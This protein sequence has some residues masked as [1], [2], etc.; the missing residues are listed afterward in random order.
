VPRSSDG[1]K[2]S[3][4]NSLRRRSQAAVRRA[5]S[6]FGGLGR[7]E[8]DDSPIS[9]KE[10]QKDR[11]I[12]RSRS[13]SVRIKRRPTSMVSLREESFDSDLLPG[14]ER[15]HRKMDEI[16]RCLDNGSDEMFVKALKKM[17]YMVAGSIV[18][19]EA[20]D[21][22]LFAT[23]EHPAKP[24]PNKYTD[25]TLT[26]EF[27]K[28]RLK[29]IEERHGKKAAKVEK[30]HIQGRQETTLT[31]TY[32]Y[33]DSLHPTQR[34]SVIGMLTHLA[35]NEGQARYEYMANAGVTEKAGIILMSS[36]LA[37]C[38][39]T[40]AYEYMEHVPP[41]EL[42]AI[43]KMQEHLEENNGKGAYQY[44]SHLPLDELR[45]LVSNLRQIQVTAER[46]D[47][48]TR[49]LI[50]AERK[51]DT[52]KLTESGGYTLI[53][54]GSD[55]ELTDSDTLSSR[56]SLNSDEEGAPLGFDTYRDGMSDYDGFDGA[57]EEDEPTPGSPGSRP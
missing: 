6:V 54:P 9:E 19:S 26:R 24:K 38:D 5:E 13:S 43:L 2:R 15:L 51:Q 17:G 55:T 50:A 56:A 33:I 32:E 25:N 52:Y 30:E 28:F 7:I 45:E 31:D 16:E 18:E 46:Y 57:S 34:A 39:G 12:R 23:E 48:V 29:M 47:A 21:Y 41:E 27:D 4:K 11:T 1:D 40:P 3:S 49:K 37:D 44:M 53:Q 14:L 35:E 42:A 10:R 8:P 22:D 20:T 36:H